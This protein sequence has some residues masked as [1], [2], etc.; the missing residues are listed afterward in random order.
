MTYETKFDITQGVKNIMA[1]LS[2]YIHRIF[3]K[4]AH[5]I[6]G[7]SGCTGTTTRQ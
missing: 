5:K 7:F 4:E 3:P 6:M 2:R 1:I